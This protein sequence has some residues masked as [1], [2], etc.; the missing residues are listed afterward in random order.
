MEWSNNQTNI[1]DVSYLGYFP[2][3]PSLFV[4]FEFEFDNAVCRRRVSDAHAMFLA[5]QTSSIKRL[6][7]YVEKV[8]LVI[9]IKN[10]HLFSLNII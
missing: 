4:E 1:I 7:V 2:I 6:P 5:L 9:A 8:K 3:F 10:V